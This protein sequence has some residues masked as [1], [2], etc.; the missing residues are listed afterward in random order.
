MG[1]VEVSKPLKEN[2]WQFGDRIMAPCPHEEPPG[3]AIPPCMGMTG[4]C[5]VHV[6]GM[7]SIPGRNLL[8]DS[9]LYCTVKKLKN[10]K[11]EGELTTEAKKIALAVLPGEMKINKIVRNLYIS[12]CRNS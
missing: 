1:W 4:S 8:P 12:I 5:C 11:E 2:Q 7:G 10:A 3:P 6:G 9:A